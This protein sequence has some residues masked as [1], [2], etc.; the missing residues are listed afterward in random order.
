[1]IYFLNELEQ[2]QNYLCSR[3]TWLLGSHRAFW[4][5]NGKGGVTVCAPGTGQNPPSDLFRA[6]RTVLCM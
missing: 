5:V 1:M 2:I 4:S 6:P 3:V